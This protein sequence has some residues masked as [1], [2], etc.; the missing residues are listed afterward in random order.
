MDTLGFALSLTGI[1]AGYKGLFCMLRRFFIQRGSPLPD[2]KAAPIAAFI[3]SL[4]LF[5]DRSPIRRR[6]IALLAVSRLADIS[7]N[8]G[9]QNSYKSFEN[10]E[11]NKG[12]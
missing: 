11:L 6:F 12:D 4:A 9:F 7:L 2:S 3:A 10:S 8:I 5:F 1:S